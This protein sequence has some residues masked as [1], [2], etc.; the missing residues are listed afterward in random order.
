VSTGGWPVA[1]VFEWLTQPLRIKAFSGTS[2]NAVQPQLW[3]AIAVYPLGAIVTKRLH[4]V[5][6]LSTKLQVVRVAL[7]ENIPLGQAVTLSQAPALET[8]PGNQLNL[9][10]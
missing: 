2:A 4:G 10:A 3:V 7:V 9:F 8:D 1:L 6:R 5:A